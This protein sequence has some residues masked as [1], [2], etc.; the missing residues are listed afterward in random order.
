MEE[1][2]QNE[3]VYEFVLDQIKSNIWKP[4]D[5]IYTEKEF[6]EKLDVSRVVVREA[7]E[8]CVALGILER[9]K[10]A[11]TFALEI[12]IGTI[13]KNIMPLLAL[14]PMDLMEVLKFRLYFEPGNIGEFMEHCTWE[15][16]CYLEKTYNKMLDNVKVNN[17]EFYNADYDFHN[18]IARGTQNSVVISISDM[19]TEV[20]KT[21]Q[22]ML[23]MRIGPEIGLRYHKEI[24]SAIKH[25]DAQ[26]A[27]LLMERHIEST[28]NYL[29]KAIGEST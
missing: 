18:A 5:K 13:M 26:V 28:I 1:T 12:D 19:L 21:S 10:G 16:V 4:G 7:L 17:E 23:N 9:R 2:S 22:K 6:C 11:G 27:I 15:D 3:K 24:I 14:K 20:L 8:K 25:K 29:E